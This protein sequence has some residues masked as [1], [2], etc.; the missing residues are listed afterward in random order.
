MAREDSRIVL[1]RQSKN[2]GAYAARNV[3]LK[4]ATGDLVT[5]HDSDDWSHPQRLERM[6][7]PLLDDQSLVGSVADWVRT[8]T[9]LHFQHWR[10]E[11][12][13]IHPSVSTLMVR[14]LQLQ[15]SGGW[16]EVR[17]A[18][19]N[20]LYQRLIRAHGAGQS[21]VSYLVYRWS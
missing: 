8:D 14:T 1:I 3:G 10:I 9:A 19:D 5:N 7:Q 17:V 12:G 13:L 21:L 6:A 11:T 4:F 18:A 15:E 2:M 16:D 20:E